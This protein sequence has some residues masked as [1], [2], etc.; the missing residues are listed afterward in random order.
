MT[1]I[2]MGVSRVMTIR[3]AAAMILALQLA[4]GAKSAEMSSVPNL[5][6]TP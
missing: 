5:A 6:S 3:S 2:I 4:S 1:F